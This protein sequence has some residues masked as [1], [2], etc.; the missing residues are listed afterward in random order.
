L[1]RRL[2]VAATDLLAWFGPAIGPAHYQIGADVR[3]A[4]LARV[5]RRA[6]DMALRPSDSPDKWQADLYAIARCQ[7]N[8]LG[9]SHIYGGGFCTHSE[10]RFYSHRRDGV[11]GRM[12]SLIWL[13]DEV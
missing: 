11:T 13:S 3:D 10:T 5:D 2:P 4:L 12:A 6:V 8:S 9:V 1:V 7:L